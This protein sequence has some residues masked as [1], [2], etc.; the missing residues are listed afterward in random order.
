MSENP[1]AHASSHVEEAAELRSQRPK[2]R[3]MVWLGSLTF[4][5]SGLVFFVLMSRLFM[6]TSQI[7][8]PASAPDPAAVAAQ[9]SGLL[10]PLVLAFFV[11]IGGLCLLVFS[12]QP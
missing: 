3:R 10:V 5:L 1:Y 4:L 7:G 9:V 8:T 11:G 6:P 2:S 12:F